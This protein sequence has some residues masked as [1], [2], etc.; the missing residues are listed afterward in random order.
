MD[1]ELSLGAL[2]RGGGKC[3]F[4]VWAP[5]AE[6]VTLHISSPRERYVSLRKEAGDYFF[7]EVADV[8]PGAQYKYRLND[9]EEFPD[10]A[11]RYQPEGVHG[12]SM[13]DDPDFEWTDSCWFG[14]P[15]KDYI[16]Y[17]IHVG[18]FTPEGTF[19]SASSYL[20]Y[21]V[22]LGITA[23]EIMP[24]A[25]FPG[26]RNWGY[27]GTYPFAVQSTYGGPKAL[28]QFVDACHAKQLAVV[29][30]VV[31]NHFGPE[32]NYVCNFGP[33]FTDR[34]Q[35]PWGDAVNFDDA[36]SDG[37]R[38]FFIEN[39]IYWLKDFHFDALRIDA[40]HA[41]LD[42]SAQPFLQELDAVIRELEQQLNR[43]IYLFPE[44]DLND[45][46]L[47][48]VREVGGFNLDA[49]WCDDFHHALITL[50]TNE[51]DGYYQDFGQL[52]QLAKSYREGYVYSGQYS[53]Y[54]LRRHG[55]SSRDLPAERFIVFS[56]NHDQ[57]GNRML[58]E[59]LTELISY[60][61]L[62]LAA[63]A[64]LLSPY[65]PLLFMGEEYGETARFPY[66]ISHSDPNLIEAV[67]KGRHEEFAEFE[68]KGEPPDPQ[69]E[70][71]FQDAKLHWNLR[72]KDSHRF[73]LQFYKELLRLRKHYPAFSHLG[74]EG[75]TVRAFEPEKVLLTR[76]GDTQ[77]QLFCLFHFRDQ[78]DSVSLTL[79]Q[80]RWQKILD[81]GDPRWSGSGSLLP[82]GVEAAGRV[83]IDV[84]PFAAAVYLK[85]T[86]T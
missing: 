28:K 81:S 23:V 51:Q 6:K 75:Q 52:W 39:A 84:P 25:Q 86:E 33:Y 50:L 26:G 46:R 85:Q 70:K 56:Q 48:R 71:T 69:D 24:V 41:I 16:F 29:L 47:I 2:Y 54:R 7:A 9:A 1:Y 20:D 79:P 14:I 55:N 74:K 34:Y 4:R 17:E 73:L 53:R 42:F 64:A 62:K 15:L 45:T 60:D 66:F 11:S 3:D 8:E 5:K 78:F 32:G 68:W 77:N 37:V 31:Y 27:D 58:G 30:D 10:P 22:D 44:S 40:V 57:V 67:R 82:A 83:K 80:G 35:T 63:A 76:K 43:R 59:R 21:L 19:E 36:C 65:L 49:Q 12:P 38:R 61:A 18:A 13:V 72:E